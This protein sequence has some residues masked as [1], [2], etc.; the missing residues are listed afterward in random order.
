MAGTAKDIQ[1]S[2][3]HQGPGDLWVIPTPP[4]DA[5]PRLTLA[6]DGTPDSVAHPACIHLGAIQ[7]A[8]TTTVKGAMAPIDL[9]QYDAPFD[10][11][12]TN[13]DAKIEA[14]MAQTEMQKLQRALGVGVYSTGAGY[15]AVTFGGLLTVPT[16]CLAAISAKRG[17]PLQHVI[18]ILFKSAAMAGFQIAIGRGAASTYKLEFLG[19][20]D[21]DRTVGKQV[22]TVYETLTDAAGINPTPKDFSVAEIYQG[23]GDL[24]L[25]DPA[26]TD[27][28]ERVT[29]DSATLTPDATAH[30]NSTHLGGTEGPITIT[31]TP[32]IGQIRLDQFDSPV[33][34]FVESIE[35]KIEAEMSQSDVEKM[36]R[37]LAFGVFG[38]AA[39]YKQVTFGGTNQPA[40][41][42]V[43]VIAPKRTDTAKAIA[44][45]LYKVNSIEGI[46]V[47]MSRKQKS[48]YKVTFAGLLDPTRTAGRQMGVIQEM[49]A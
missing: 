5:T 27:V 11:Y 19:L 21:P 49:I 13:V 38:E 29:I 14:E 34:V 25:I 45:C 12:A 26:P 20:G 23:P 37:A 44:A 17:S 35:A 41:I 18:S 48:T 32:T 39:E 3:I 7:S 2:E 1:V 30:A 31:V 36:S 47:V 10:N 40:T 43:A 9:D 33:D 46:Q 4:L 22:G 24:W 8:I 16:I 6:T 28:A 42:C 15:K